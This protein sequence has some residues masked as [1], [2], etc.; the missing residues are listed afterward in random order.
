MKAP[1]K[2]VTRPIFRHN[3]IYDK[4]K[5]EE[6]NVD[7]DIKLD[8]SEMKNEDSTIFNK[9]IIEFDIEESIF[10]IDQTENYSDDFPS[11]LID[12]FN[13][14]IDFTDRRFEFYAPMEFD[15]FM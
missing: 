2:T 1:R 6:K 4:E 15:E 11:N 12:S 13:E 5:S 8:P 14:A 7:L 9:S 3:E 10:S